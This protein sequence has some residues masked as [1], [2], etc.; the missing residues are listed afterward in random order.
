MI[1]VI[2]PNATQSFAAQMAYAENVTYQL[3][4]GEPFPSETPTG[5]PRP[6]STSGSN[7]GGGDGGDSDGGGGGGG[8]STG[9]IAGIAIGAAAVLIIAAALIYLCGRRG[10]FEKAYRKSGLPGFG[11]GTA[12]GGSA[13]P[14]MVEANYANAPVGG[15]GI[16]VVGRTTPKSPG[17]MTMSTFAGHDNGTLRSSGY[18]PGGTTPSLGP[19]PGYGHGQ[20]QH[21]YGH[22]GD[23]VHP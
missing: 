19:V 10:G 23:V 14:H 22:G 6:T 11:A 21:G 5:L 8:L 17:Q 13:S 2:N 1:G 7:S 20:Q 3:A 15:V 4:P 9:A 12:A 18:F 16:G